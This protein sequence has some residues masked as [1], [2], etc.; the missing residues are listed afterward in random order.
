MASPSDKEIF[1][2]CSSG[3][4]KDNQSIRQV[5]PRGVLTPVINRLSFSCGV[6]V[7]KWSVIIE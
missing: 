4:G 7:I 5:S 2:V 3:F 6:R 1:T